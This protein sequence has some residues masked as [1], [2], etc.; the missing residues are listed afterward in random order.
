[1]SPDI[2]LPKTRTGRSAPS[3]RSATVRRGRRLE[4]GN[5]VGVAGGDTGQL[6]ML[7][8]Q[9]GSGGGVEKRDLDSKESSRGSS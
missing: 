3:A 8:V 9:E 4:V 1:M 5:G 7:S 2:T 6:E